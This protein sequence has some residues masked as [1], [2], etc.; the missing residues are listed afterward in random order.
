[1]KTIWFIVN[2]ISGTHDKSF[3]VSQIPKYFPEDRFAVEIL[4]TSYSGH[5]AEIAKKAVAAGVDIVV[6]VGGDGTVNETARALVH[7]DVA[8][9]IVPSGRDRKS[10]V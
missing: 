1:M 3:I 10:V 4:Y 8:L 7:S 6:A 5:A 9:G 2:P